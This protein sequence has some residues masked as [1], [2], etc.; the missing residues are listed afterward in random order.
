M[1]INILKVAQIEYLEAKEF[2]EIERSGLGK[3]FEIDIKEGIE[4]IIKFPEAWPIERFEIR[5]FILHKFPYKILYSIQEDE[6]IVLAFAHLHRKPN[7]WEE[8]VKE[9]KNIK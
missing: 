3:K 6:I 9:I 1:K 5:R 7:Y 8:R 4:K 2:Y